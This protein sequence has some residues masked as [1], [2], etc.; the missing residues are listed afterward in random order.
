MEIDQYIEQTVKLDEGTVDDPDYKGGFKVDQCFETLC[1]KDSILSKWFLKMNP[2]L[3]KT[4][5]D[6]SVRF[7][8]Q[9]AGCT[10]NQKSFIKLYC[11]L[12]FSS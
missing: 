10:K 9:V 1:D 4:Q 8:S 7:Y 6:G 2:N 3:K 12:F 11:L 5:L